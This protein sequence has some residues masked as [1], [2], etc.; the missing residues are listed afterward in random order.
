MTPTIYI[1]NGPNLNTLGLREPEIYG[2]ATLADVQTRCEAAGSEAGFDIVFRQSNHEGVLVEWIHE[3][4]DAAVAIII[5]AGAYTH[6]SLAIHDALRFFGKPIVEVHISNI[7][8]REEI[9]HKSL[10][11]PIAAGMIVG[12]G[13]IGY[14]LAITAL[15]A[16]LR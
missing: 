15:K 8:A 16:R 2:S 3:A 11:A 14:E 10:I 1:L 12:F 9:R 7:H 4:R 13:S 6:T 5:N